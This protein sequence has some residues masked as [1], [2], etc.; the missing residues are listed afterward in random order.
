MRKIVAG[1]F[2]SLD[3]VVEAPQNWH[4]PYYN[5]E[6]FDVVESQ[7]AAADT[8]LLGRRTYEEFAAYWPNQESG[9]PL[10]DEIN[11]MEKLVVSTTL[12]S[13]DW[14]NSTLISG[15]VVEELR[16]Q[17]QRPGKEI[18]VTGSPTLVRFLIAEGLLDELQLLVH[19]IIVGGGKRLFADGERVPLRL[20]ESRTL[21]TG[22]LYLTYVPDTS[23]V[24]ER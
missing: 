21:K 16:R 7:L 13:L 12:R 10:A 2:V 17:K 22:V 6:M 19:P 1:L 23:E 20:T 15:D 8:M 9:V 3:G 11:G 5:D 18:S 4:F 24:A 14:Q